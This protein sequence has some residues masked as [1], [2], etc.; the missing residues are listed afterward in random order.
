ME[1]HVGTAG[2]GF[3]ESRWGDFSS[4]AYF[5]GRAKSCGMWLLCTREAAVIVPLSSALG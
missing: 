2:L 1:I 5:F 3:F 4:L